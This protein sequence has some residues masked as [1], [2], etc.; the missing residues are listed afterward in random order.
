M[1][2]K[3]VPVSGN[4][5]VLNIT[6]P[7]D[8][9]VNPPKQQTLSGYLSNNDCSKS[10][11]GEFCFRGKPISG[12]NYE[13]IL[14]FLNGATNQ[15][16]YKIRQVATILLKIKTPLKLLSKKAVQALGI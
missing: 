11:T 2:Y 15:K 9:I 13:H 14:Q 10:S 5:E 6:L 8:I 1:E 16:P 4:C 3:L 7:S 12:S